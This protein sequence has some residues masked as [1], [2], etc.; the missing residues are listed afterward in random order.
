MRKVE[1]WWS[2]LPMN[3]VYGI[4]TRNG[5]RAIKVIKK[6]SDENHL[7]LTSMKTRR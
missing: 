3:E 7:T 2:F 1:E 6:G 4:V 5:L